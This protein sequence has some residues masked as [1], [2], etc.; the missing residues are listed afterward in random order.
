[1]ARKKKD[2][3]P[4]GP[5]G[6]PEWI[7]TFTD[8]ISLLVTFFVLLMTFSSLEEREALKIAAIL[9]GNLG[10]H[11]VSGFVAASI[12]NDLI[13]SSDVLRGGLQ[14]H[15]RPN[16]ELASNL[17]EMGQGQSDERLEMDLRAA[18]DGLVIEFDRAASFAPGSAEVPADLAQS[19]GEIGRVL[20]HY[21]YLVV[22]E[23]YTDSAFQPTPRYQSA[24]E[25]AFARGA[26][27][28]RAMLGASSLSPN[29][30]QVSSHGDRDPRADEDTALG[31]Q[32]NRRVQLRVLS[33]SRARAD[34]LALQKER[35]R[36]EDR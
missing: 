11:D 17:A 18:G 3:G 14:P 1:M 22:V 36:E 13:A 5:P 9:T 25:L 30:V 20:E 21:P 35:R 34:H 12:E 23:G 27:A 28:A 32:E 4:S 10:V 8:M 19:L 7:V 24:D 31:R 15:T 26:A 33:L 2:A 29:L 16:D 6:A